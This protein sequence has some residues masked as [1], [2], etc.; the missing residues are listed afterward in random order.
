MSK[1]RRPITREE[2]RR[3]LRRLLSRIFG[4]DWC[5]SWPSCECHRVL[6]FYGGELTQD[7]EWS[8]EELGVAERRIFEALNCVVRRCPDKDTRLSFWVQLA[9]SFWN[10]QRELMD[11]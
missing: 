11:V 3:L 9:D 7:R 2:K 1:R 5:T 6:D 4:K 8:L 10:K